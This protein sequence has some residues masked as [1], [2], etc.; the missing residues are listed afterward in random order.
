MGN[1][2]IKKEAVIHFCSTLL[3][4]IGII[5]KQETELSP[6]DKTFQ[7]VWQAHQE[8]QNALNNFNFISEPDLIDYFVYNIET[9]VKKYMFLLKQAKEQNICVSSLKDLIE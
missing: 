6:E 1:R 7:E 8:W 2:Q 9:S 3:A 5:P 4:K